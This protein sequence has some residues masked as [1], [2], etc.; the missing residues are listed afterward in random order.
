MTTKAK[1]STKAEPAKKTANVSVK[2][3]AQKL[4]KEITALLAEEPRDMVKINELRAKLSEIWDVHGKD[5]KL[6]G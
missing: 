5:G 6:P 1:P 2:A 4:K 3:Q